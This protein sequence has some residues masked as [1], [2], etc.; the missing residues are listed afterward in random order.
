MIYNYPRI[1]KCGHCGKPV[2]RD[3]RESCGYCTQAIHKYCSNCRAAGN[4]PGIRPRNK[5]SLKERIQQPVIPPRPVQYDIPD[6]V[7]PRI[8]YIPSNRPY[9]VRKFVCSH[10]DTRRKAE[11]YLGHLSKQLQNPRAE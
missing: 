4:L 3:D 10:E 1:T 2:H 8:D 6:I 11:Y 7:W 5:P 9:E